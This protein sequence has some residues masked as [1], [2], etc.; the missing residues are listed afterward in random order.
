MEIITWIGTN[1]IGLFEAGAETM[2]SYIT[3]TIPLL[4]VLLCFMRS[5]IGF[6]GQ[7]RVNRAV[8]KFAKYKPLRY[9]LMPIIADLMLTNP[10]AYTI[11]AFVEEDEKPAFYDAAVSFCHPIT[12]LFPYANAGEL[13]V[14]LGIAEGYEAAG[15][16]EP[17]LAVMYFLVGI[18]VIF[19]RGY[20][21]EWM[22]KVLKKNRVRKAQTAE[23]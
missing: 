7:D 4:L 17:T 1:F 3:D 16:D 18:I 11:G 14:Y 13:F 5:I 21:T 8:R 9:T 6:I 15:G 22:T 19:M 20:V 23:A 2:L 10:M 12:G